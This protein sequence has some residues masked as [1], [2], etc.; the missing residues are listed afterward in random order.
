M[1]LVQKIRDLEVQFIDFRSQM[2]RKIKQINE[3]VPNKLDREMKRIET[4]EIETV[5]TSTR[6]I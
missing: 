6:D 3:E 1:E 4:K 2:D 5:R